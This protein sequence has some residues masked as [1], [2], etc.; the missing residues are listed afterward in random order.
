[1]AKQRS[2]EIISQQNNH[3]MECIQS[4]LI[5]EILQRRTNGGERD[6]VIFKKP[7]IS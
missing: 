7:V 5:A 4:V 3:K 1:M 6:K 2:S